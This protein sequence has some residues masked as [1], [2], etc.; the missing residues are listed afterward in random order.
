[1]LFSIVLA[2]TTIFTF[3]S[4]QSSSKGTHG[5][6]LTVPSLHTFITSYSIVKADGSLI[7]VSKTSDP[8]LFSALAPSMGVFGVVVEVEMQCV[9]LQYLEARFKVISFD[10]LATEG[11]FETFMRENK[12]AR[13]VV[14]P[15]IN[16]AT[17][18]YANPI[19]QDDM[20]NAIKEGAVDSSNGYMNF[21]DENEK[22]W[23]EK[24]VILDKKKKYQEADSLLHKVLA[25]QESRLGRYV[26]RYNYVLCKER[27]NGIPHA[28]IEFNF[29]F[30]KNLQVLQ[31]VRK[32]C[33]EHR[34]PYYNFEIRTTKQ[35]DAMLSC[36]NGRD[37]MWIDF[38]AKAADSSAFFKDIETVLKP[39]G[40]RKHWAKGLGNTDPSYVVTQFPKMKD[41][42]K[43]MGELDREGKFRNVEGEQWYQD[44][45]DLVDQFEVK[46][47]SNLLSTF[48]STISTEVLKQ[49]RHGSVLSVSS[50]DLNQAYELADDDEE[51]NS[52]PLA[53]LDSK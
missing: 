36:C 17:I 11:V 35:D 15:S 13:V 45:K 5:G 33:S 8:E 14:Y 12:Y 27:N 23:L 18:W 52:T 50:N 43:L 28:D 38:Q 30:S 46:E 31:T 24:F 29:D 41:F 7:K 44:M 48:H 34:V 1:M 6:A 51:M 25:S 39:I 32:Y 10:E 21:R 47:E 2:N 37:A 3:Q 40:F 22:A 16:K 26:G 53:A 20:V 42:V 4:L 49:S 19:S 9:P